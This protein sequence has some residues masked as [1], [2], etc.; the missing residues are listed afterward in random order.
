MMKHTVM[1]F[2][3]KWFI[4]LIILFLGGSGWGYW[5]YRNQPNLYIFFGHIMGTTYHVKYWSPLL[6]KE[7]QASIKNQVTKALKQVDQSMSTYKPDSE[8][9]QFNRWPVNKPFLAS[10]DLFYLLTESISL[11]KLSQGAYDVTIG[12]LVNLWG[13]GPNALK[14]QNNTPEFIQAKKNP[15]NNQLPSQEAIADAKKNVGYQYLILDP[16]HSSVTKSKA[17]FV[18]L[19]SIAKGYG[20]DQA[21]EVLL[22]N[23]ISTYLVEVGGEIRVQMNKKLRDNPWK[24][25]IES[26]DKNPNHQL[27]I[28]LSNHSIATS[29]NYHNFYE[30]DH[31]Q[32]GH[33]I[34]FNTGYPDKKGMISATVVSNKATLSD[35]YST[36]FMLLQ[37]KKAIE[38][39]RSMNFPIYLTYKDTKT[40]T[41]KTF[42]N[43]EFEQL[44][45]LKR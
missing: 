32:Y 38:L 45:T 18:D 37:P 25:A 42:V 31:V 17:V 8:L 15:D 16:K 43:S 19:S 36:L 35:A 12:H 13:F 5:Q 10:P 24:I 6:S 34:D 20:V 28:S 9:M 11:S 4:G 14:P 21:A 30:I 33:E 23:K 2:N 7:Q 44:A 40:N 27:F 1:K 22:K 26:A 29:G 3:Y 41:L 39:A